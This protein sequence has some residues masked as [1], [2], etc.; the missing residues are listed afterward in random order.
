MLILCSYLLRN[1]CNLGNKTLNLVYNSCRIS[2]INLKIKIDRVNMSCIIHE[3]QSR[4]NITEKPTEE[5][6]NSLKM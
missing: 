2:Y 6:K 1:L 3:V 5:L 4:N